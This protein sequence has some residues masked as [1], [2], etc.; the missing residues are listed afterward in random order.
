VVA[1]YTTWDFNGRFFKP[2]GTAACKVAKKYY[3]IGQDNG[4]GFS[5][6]GIGRGTC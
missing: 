6:D 3:H 5:Y 2:A 1:F 4:Y